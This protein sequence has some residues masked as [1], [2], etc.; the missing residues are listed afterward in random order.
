MAGEFYYGTC[1][2][3]RLLNALLNCSIG[4]YRIRVSSVS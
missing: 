3:N 4:G 1:M 2:A